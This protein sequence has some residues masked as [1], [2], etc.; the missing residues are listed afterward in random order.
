[1]TGT[2]DCKAAGKVA[3]LVNRNRCEAKSDCVRVCPYDVFAIQPLG[4]AER[5]GLS[6]AGRLKSWA[7]GHRQAYV[8]KTAECHACQLCVSSCPEKAI[9]LVPLTQVVQPLL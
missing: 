2:G 9:T 5:A 3:P 8:V 1:M 6:L 7:H 4:G